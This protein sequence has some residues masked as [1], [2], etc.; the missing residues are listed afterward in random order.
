[1]SLGQAPV[2]AIN[3]P[4]MLKNML[5]EGFSTVHCLSELIDDSQG[6]SATRIHIYMDSQNN[7]LIVADDANGMTRD[8]LES[9]HYFHS[10]SSASNKHGRFGIGRKHAL[11]HFTGLKGMAQTVSRSAENNTLSQ[12]NIDFPK[13]ISSGNLYLHSHGVEEEFRPTWNKYAVDQDGKGT[14]TYLECDKTV[15]A[16]LVQRVKSDDV[17]NSLRYFLGSTYYNYL[18]A[19]GQV[20]LDVDGEKFPIA[21]IDRLCWD[22][23]TEKEEQFLSIYYNPVTREVRAYFTEKYLK[24]KKGK[25]GYLTKGKK[26]FVEGSPTDDL[27][28]LGNVNLRG[29]YSD[30]WLHLQKQV[31]TSMGVKV[32]G[33]HEEGV[34]EL[35]RVLGGT[36]IQ[37]N[38]KLVAMLPA[39]KAKSGDKASYTYVENSRYSV[40]FSAVSDDNLPTDDDAYTLD[41]V[42]NVQ[43]N[44]SRIDTAL[45]DANVWATIEYI[46]H[47]YAISCYKRLHPQAEEEDTPVDEVAG[48]AAPAEA[49]TAERLTSFGLTIHKQQEPSLIVADQQEEQDQ[50]EQ[51]QEEQAQEEQVAD[52][53]EEEEQ[54]QGEEQV[55]DVQEEEE[56]AQ[57]EQQAPVIHETPSA[58]V[59]VAQHQRE[60]SKNPRDLLIQMKRMISKYSGVDID[61]AIAKASNVVEPG[62][63]AKWRLLQETDDTIQKL[64]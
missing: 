43:V 33:E 52:D 34:E 7:R 35:R 46:R 61:A 63:T 36:D 13:V 27:T 53:Q 16:D 32:P 50:E 62:I 17:T 9:S 14:M 30:D 3:I 18:K 40:K 59:G 57:E 25:R 64:L 6:A 19:G 37:R 4:G 42:F 60:V 49:S 47:K 23:V 12:L 44:K 48:V 20:I 45:I 58:V 39:E 5:R 22:T 29:A 24:T 55:A 31:L 15:L 10:R 51:A 28:H 56:Q 8:K 41:D 54:A 11:V 1:M 21:P 2:N 38:L 26:K